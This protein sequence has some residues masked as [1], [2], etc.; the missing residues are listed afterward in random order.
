VLLCSQSHNSVIKDV[1]PRYPV[2]SSQMVI[3]L[4]PTHQEGFSYRCVRMLRSALGSIE[5]RQAPLTATRAIPQHENA[6]MGVP[7]NL[8]GGHV[9]VRAPAAVTTARLG[10]P[11]RTV[12]INKYIRVSAVLPSEFDSLLRVSS[13]YPRNKVRVQ[14]GSKLGLDRVSGSDLTH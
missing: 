5:M 2:L 3:V 1:G 7:C 8:N 13:R 10:H 14:F 12:S 9:D 4:Q 6:P 11:N